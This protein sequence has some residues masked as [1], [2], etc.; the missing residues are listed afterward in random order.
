[1]REVVRDVP[2]LLAQLEEYKQSTAVMRQK[3]ETVKQQMSDNDI[4]SLVQAA[5]GG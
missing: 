3:V 1:M 4:D 5:L 2:Q